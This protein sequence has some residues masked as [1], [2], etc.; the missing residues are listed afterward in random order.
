MTNKLSDPIFSRILEASLVINE[1]LRDYGKPGYPLSDFH[2]FGRIFENF[3][4][5]SDVNST[6]EKLSNSGKTVISLDLLGSDSKAIA[7]GLLYAERLI[8]TL[9]RI[10]FDNHWDYDDGIDQPHWQGFEEFSSFCLKHQN[11]IESGLILPIPSSVHFYDNNNQTS[12]NVCPENSTK[13]VSDLTVSA[14]DVVRPIV[15][16]QSTA[17]PLLP[18]TSIQNNT[19][20][21]YEYILELREKHKES[22]DIYTRTVKSLYKSS[23]E[24]DAITR[25][26]LID[27]SSREIS[28]AVS[29]YVREQRFKGADIAGN[30]IAASLLFQ[31]NLPYAHFLAVAFSG[32][33]IGTK[34]LDVIR[35]NMDFRESVKQSPYFYTYAAHKHLASRIGA[36][37]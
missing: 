37:K 33:N 14:K 18:F 6:L 31:A 25:L 34:L 7:F 30:I 28:S 5:D 20:E 16:L 29:K 4:T 24:R 12:F 35:M 36:S 9:P 26:E 22:F 23:S 17:F 27:E 19:H 21:P 15:S 10:D 13:K 3:Q 32:N 2:E 8:V 1:R 11:L